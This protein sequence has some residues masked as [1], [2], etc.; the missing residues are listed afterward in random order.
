MYF[1]SRVSPLLHG[2]NFTGCPAYVDRD[3]QNGDYR[4]DVYGGLSTEAGGAAFMLRMNSGELD[5][6]IF[7]NCWSDDCRGVVKHFMY[8]SLKG[9]PVSGRV[10]RLA[11]A[12][13]LNVRNDY[14]V[15]NEHGTV[16]LE[17]VVVRNCSGVGG[18]LV[19]TTEDKQ[20]GHPRAIVVAEDVVFYGYTDAPTRFLADGH[21]ASLGAGA[22]VLC[23]TQ[24]DGVCPVVK[25]QCPD[26]SFPWEAARTGTK[27]LVETE[28]ID[29]TR[30]DNPPRTRIPDATRLAATGRIEVTV[31]A[32]SGE[33][34]A[35]MGLGGTGNDQMKESDVSQGTASLIPTGVGFAA[36]D[37]FADTAAFLV[38][39]VLS[40]S[41]KFS[42]S[43]VLT[44]T[45]L[46]PDPVLSPQLPDAS[47][48][49][50]KSNRGGL[51]AGV[52]A[53]ILA[54]LA[55]ALVLL[56]LVRRKK[57]NEEETGLSDRVIMGG[58]IEQGIEDYGVSELLSQEDP[59]SI[60]GSVNIETAST[61]L[62]A[63]EDVEEI[64]Y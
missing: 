9:V 42:P 59:N 46:P 39:M 2:V 3:L 28:G 31:M 52:T 22:L 50:T 23:E 58:C 25:V 32:A 64:A 43:A 16:R 7:D 18:W 11:G 1:N 47:L 63:R 45:T 40:A 54:L 35:S 15:W 55:A 13:F 51:I 48:S 44:A 20:V 37:K 30:R 49:P 19:L 12:V 27:E 33:I 41:V 62:E 5:F 24:W 10:S 6:L 60:L 56:F 38:S 4:N 57:K 29:P 53:G 14:P 34:E 21:S 17:N 8:E 36:S 26:F 61:A